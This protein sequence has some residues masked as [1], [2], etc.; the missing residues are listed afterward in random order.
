MR[1]IHFFW[2]LFVFGLY[3]MLYLF[4]PFLMDMLVA[5]LLCIATMSLKERIEKRVKLSWLASLLV[6]VLLLSLLFVPLFYVAAVLADTLS[7]IDPDSFRGFVESSKAQMFK[8]MALFPFAQEKLMENLD[9]INAS[10]IL[11]HALAWS[12]A[13]GK[14]SLSFVTDTVFVTI[15]LFLFFYYG[16]AFY[17][18][19]LRLIPFSRRESHQLFGEVAGVLGVVFYSSLAS[20]ILQG[21]L[22]AVMIAFLGYNGFLFGV[23]Y[24][25]ASLVPVVGGLL[26]WLPLASYEYYLGNTGNSLLI[27]LYSMIVIATVADNVIKPLLIGLINRVILKNPVQI[28]EL[29]IFFA[30]FAG[31]TT[32][33]FWGMVLGPTITA[34]FIALLRLYERGFLHIQE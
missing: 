33:G 20:V 4:K 10:A 5:G 19:A 34:F 28:N 1:P 21:F 23:L 16:R 31:L 11:Q 12:G 25:V 26:V 18:Y 32:F 3:W 14:K 30:I 6:V 17:D 7:K 27:A 9:K 24:G 2:I 15:F 8:W 22:F 13:L 29:V